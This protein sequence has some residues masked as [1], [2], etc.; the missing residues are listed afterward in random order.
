METVEHLIVGAGPAGLRAGQVLADAGREA[1]VAEKHAEIGPKTCAGGLTPKTVALLRGLGLPDDVGLTS[2]GLVA[3]AAGSPGDARPGQ[4]VGRHPVTKRAWAVPVGLGSR[5]RS[6]GASGLRGARAGPGAPDRA[7]GRNPREMAAS[8]RRRRLRLRRAPGTRPSLAARLLRGRVQPSGRTA[9]AAPVECDRELRGG[10]FWVFPHDGLHLGRRGRLE[11]RGPAGGAPRLP[12][13]P[14]RADALPGH[15]APL[16]GAT[17]EVDFRGLH[18]ADGV[19]L[20]GDAAGVPSALTAEGI[21]SALAYR[22][23]GC[24]P[25]PRSGASLR[26]SGAVAPR[27]APARQPRR[28]SS[29]VAGPGRCAPVAAPAV[30]LARGAAPLAK[31]FLA[32]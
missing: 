25:Y 20:A 4:H 19:H 28:L 26:P 13:R 21:Y 27:Q 14:A 10:Y 17:L 2:V 8:D 32:G 11:A 7:G 1:L 18:F 16:E 24:P 12:R 23:R 29:T 15:G 9:R 31:W 22:R 3:F 6:R 30:P 5:G